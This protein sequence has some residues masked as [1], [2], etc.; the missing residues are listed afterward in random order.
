MTVKEDIKI[1]SLV[2][3]ILGIIV[4]AAF[5]GYMFT[6]LHSVSAPINIVDYDLEVTFL[7]GDVELYPDVEDHD[8]VSDTLEFMTID[9]NFKDGRSIRISDVV[10]LEYIES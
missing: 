5:I 2:Y 9:V 8:V 10:S 7:N 4:V 6:F 1:E 3:I